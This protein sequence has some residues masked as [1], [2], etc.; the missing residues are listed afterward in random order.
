MQRLGAGITSRPEQERH[1]LAPGRVGH[2][3][4]V[5]G[6]QGM[7]MRAGVL[8]R[9]GK[10]PGW[11]LRAAPTGPARRE[12]ELLP[13]PAGSHTHALT[14]HAV[15]VL[16]VLLCSLQQL[17]LPHWLALSAVRGDAWPPQSSC[18]AGTAHLC[19]SLLQLPCCVIA[20]V[21]AD[22]VL[23]VAC[24]HWVGQQQHPACT[25]AVWRCKDSEQNV[26]SRLP[27][28]LKVRCCA[29]LCFGDGRCTE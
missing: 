3:A 19:N 7:V 15:L 8:Q 14:D 26:S 20:E 1:A 28:L 21:D 11:R 2:L 9:W 24:H 6:G 4:T 22:G 17:A 23:G 12:A 10:P 18:P 13:L 16:S 27:G 25:A 29:R 5:R